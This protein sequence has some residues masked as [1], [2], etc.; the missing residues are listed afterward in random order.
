MAG[1]AGV[2]FVVLS[3]AIAVTAPPIPTLTASGAEIVTY[4]ANNQTGFLVGNYLG[5]VAI[6]PAF[7][8]IAYLTIQ[9]RAGETDDGSLWVLVIL[10][11]ATAFAAAMLI[12]V[13]LQTAAVVAPGGPPQT[14]KAVSDA[15]NLAFGFFFVPQ[16]AAIASVAWGF[17]VTGAM[18]RSIAWLG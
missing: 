16:A 12:F 1:I 18:V 4:Y 11:N 6:L 2:V 5:A 14:A 9:I 15:G 13:L 7:L 10:S 8:L 17:L 3:S